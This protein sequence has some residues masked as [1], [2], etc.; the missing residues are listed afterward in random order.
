MFSPLKIC[1]NTQSFNNPLF[2]FK[3]YLLGT[4]IVFFIDKKVKKSY[5]KTQNSTKNTQV[6][7]K[8][9]VIDIDECFFA[10]VRIFDYLKIKK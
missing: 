3:K 6:D 9:M 4:K 7:Y 1:K 8:K 10:F 2:K 5:K